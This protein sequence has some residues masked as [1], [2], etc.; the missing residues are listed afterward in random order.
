MSATATYTWSAFNVIDADSGVRVG[1]RQSNDNDL[2]MTGVLVRDN[3]HRDTTHKLVIEGKTFYIDINGVVRH[4]SPASSYEGSTVQ[5][6]YCDMKTTYGTSQ[7]IT[8]G[9]S[10]GSEEVATLSSMEPRDQFALYAMQ[11]IMRSLP[12]PQAIDDANILSNCRAAYRWAQGMMIA[13]ADARAER[14]K[15]EESGGDSEEQSATTTRSVVDTSTG[16]DTEKLLGNIAASVDDLTKQMKAN[17]ESLL[18]ATL[19]TQVDNATQT[20]GDSTTEKK[21]KVEGAG[22]GSN[23]TRDDVNDAADAV[24]DVLGYN[25]AVGKAP[26]RFAIANF[27][28]KLVSLDTPLSWL[29]KKGETDIASASTFFTQYKDEMATALNDKFEATL[30]AAKSYTD[31]KL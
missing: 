22:G 10:E 17:N 4:A 31:S 5:M 6:V 2:S 15:Q 14:K 3:K 21:L 25:T 7:G 12:S 16:T 20:S 11:A 30:N 13:S 8:R 19:K 1:F 18:K 23:I 9:V 29:R 27:L 28:K 26:V 24:T